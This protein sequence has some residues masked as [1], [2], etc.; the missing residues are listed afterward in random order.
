M[1]VADLRGMPEYIDSASLRTV[2]DKDNTE[3]LQLLTFRVVGKDCIISLKEEE[4]QQLRQQIH[5]K[6]HTN[7]ILEEKEKH[8]GQLNQQLRQLWI[9]NT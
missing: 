8:L 9:E 6:D 4:N 3:V 5:E 7:R 2:Q 1:R